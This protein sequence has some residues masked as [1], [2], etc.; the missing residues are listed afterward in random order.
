MGRLPD[1]LQTSWTRFQ[2][3]VLPVN[4]DKD[5]KQMERNKEAEK[6]INNAADVA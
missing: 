3:S 2:K 1:P 6:V 4:L 5:K